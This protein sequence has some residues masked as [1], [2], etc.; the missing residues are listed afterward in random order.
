MTDKKRTDD[1]GTIFSSQLDSQ[2]FSILLALGGGLGIAETLIPTLIFICLYLVAGIY[3]AALL[4]V[5]CSAL[6]LLYRLCLRQGIRHAIFGF[7]L[8]VI[9]AIWAYKSGNAGNFFTLGFLINGV[10]ALIFSVSIIVKQPI[11]G[12]LGALFAGANKIWKTPAHAR[13]YHK[14]QL[15]TL[16]FIILFL[17]RLGLELPLYY[18]NL[19]VALGIMRIILGPP[20]FALA[21]WVIWAV[22]KEPFHQLKL[23]AATQ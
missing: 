22:L 17:L 5:G 10:Y 16:I 6:F 8:L 21:A 23:A 15:A 20:A 11:I 4:A 19:Y 2:N 7:V 1:F 14:S 13:Y 9:G 18:W 12:F 3:W